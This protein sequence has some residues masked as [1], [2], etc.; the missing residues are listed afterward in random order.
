MSGLR[1]EPFAARAATSHPSNSATQFPLIALVVAEPLEVVA[2][3]GIRQRAAGNV[4]RVKG[5]RKQ[6]QILTIRMPANGNF[7]QLPRAR[8]LVPGDE[9]ADS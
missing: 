4:T 3:R 1:S 9:R 8:N 6:L 7:S 2:V 5:L